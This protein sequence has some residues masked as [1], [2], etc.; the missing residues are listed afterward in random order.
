MLLGYIVDIR[1]VSSQL[2]TISATRLRI[3]PVHAKCP[4]AIELLFLPMPMSPLKGAHKGKLAAEIH[5]DG[6]TKTA[7]ASGQHNNVFHD[8][9]G[10]GFIRDR[11]NHTCD[12]T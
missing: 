10:G 6:V 9:Y 5:G 12:F 8:F 11:S 7:L 3:A 4:Q 1:I 2:S